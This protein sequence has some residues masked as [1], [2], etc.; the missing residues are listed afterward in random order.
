M[1]VE[2][3]NCVHRKNVYM[4]C[5]KMNKYGLMLSQNM[6]LYFVRDAIENGL[7]SFW[8]LRAES[9]DLQNLEPLNAAT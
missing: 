5:V 7:K 3:V 2:E 4:V 6:A 9:E 8:P 1:N